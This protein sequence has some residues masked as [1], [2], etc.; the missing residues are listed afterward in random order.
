[1]KK[2]LTDRADIEHLVDEFY[3]KV[4]Q[5]G[6]IGHFF[7]QVVQISWEK[8]MP[9]MYQFWESVLLGQASYRGNAMLPHL[10]LNRKSPLRPE[11]FER[12]QKLWHETLDEHFT[13]E[14]V[15]EAKRKA[16]QMALLMQF[17]IEKSGE[18]GFIL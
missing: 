2:E 13:G 14:K 10:S 1:M 4:L 15:A 11:H 9:V 18:E 12:W 16:E 17:K 5:D 3:K 7:T 8:H 6:L